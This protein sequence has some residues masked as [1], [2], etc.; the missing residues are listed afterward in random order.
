MEVLC[1]NSVGSSVPHS[2]AGRAAWGRK[3]R[4]IYLLIATLLSLTGFASKS[5]A[6]TVNPGDTLLIEF[7]A[8]TPTPGVIDSLALQATPLVPN[9]GCITI[10]EGSDGGTGGLRRHHGG[11]CGQRAYHDGSEQII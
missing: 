7:A 4:I 9:V 1:Q 2:Q 8:P 3:M 6:I 5:L 11:P 10:F